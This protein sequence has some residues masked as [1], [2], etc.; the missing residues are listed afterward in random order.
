[1]SKI[2][3][4]T[5]A[6]T[7]VALGAVVVLFVLNL[8]DAILTLLAV[9]RHAEEVNLVAAHLLEAGPI[10]FLI[11]KI[12]LVSAA[13]CWAWRRIRTGAWSPFISAV[14][15]SACATVMFCVVGM[16]AAALIMPV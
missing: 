3:G 6:A 9:P 10:V 14:V 4:R 15:L 16:L 11:V 13:L 8:A 2:D 5:D 1:M 7:R 12:L